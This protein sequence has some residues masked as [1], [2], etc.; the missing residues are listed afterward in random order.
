MLSL[1]SSRAPLEQ[2]GNR[3]MQPHS[4]FVLSKYFLCSKK[5]WTC[6]TLN[7]DGNT[8]CSSSSHLRDQERY[9]TMNIQYCLFVCTVCPYMSLFL[10]HTNIKHGWQHKLRPVLRKEVKGSKLYIF[11]THCCLCNAIFIHCVTNNLKTNVSSRFTQQRSYLKYLKWMS[12][13]FCSAMFQCP[14]W[15]ATDWIVC[16][17]G[18]KVVPRGCQK[19]RF[20]LIKMISYTL[21]TRRWLLYDDLG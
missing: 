11:T 19:N 20:L 16:Y 2:E 10:T 14:L 15:V 12:F 7:S 4:V 18:F 6:M 13:P 9:I 1:A 8:W 5:I 21:K 17:S 3:W